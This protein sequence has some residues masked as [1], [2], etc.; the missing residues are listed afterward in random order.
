MVFSQVAPVW[1]GEPHKTAN[2][3]GKRNEI[4]TPRGAASVRPQLCLWIPGGVLKSGSPGSDGE[5]GCGFSWVLGGHPGGAPRL[6]GPAWRAGQ[7][8]TFAFFAV[9]ARFF[10]LYPGLSR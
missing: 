5:P 2:E 4:C 10:R 3:V 7:N 1:H 8:G 9:H 6:P